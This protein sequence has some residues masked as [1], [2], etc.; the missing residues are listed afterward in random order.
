MDGRKSSPKNYD[1]L[2]EA[3]R[4][5]RPSLDAVTHD[6]WEEFLTNNDRALSEAGAMM[7]VFPTLQGN[8]V[9]FHS[10]A[11][12]KLSNLAIVVEETST[13]VPGLMDGCRYDDLD[14]QDRK[15]VV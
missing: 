11:Q 7:F 2:Y 9:G 15:S 5:R 14:A 8:A 6:E 3:I 13:P 1:Q 10:C 12:V 4:K